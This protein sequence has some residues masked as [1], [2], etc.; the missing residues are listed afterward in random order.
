MRMCYAKPVNFKNIHC[1][2]SSNNSISKPVLR[3]IFTADSRQQIGWNTSLSPWDLS[4][5]NPCTTAYCIITAHRVFARD[6]KSH[7]GQCRHRTGSG[8][9]ENHEKTRARYLL[10]WTNTQ[11][12]QRNNK[13]HVFACEFA[14]CILWSSG[15]PEVPV[16]RHGDQP[17]GRIFIF[18]R[19]TMS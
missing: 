9:T 7:A 16:V 5:Q 3:S 17:A 13:A 12:L 14:V 19:A 4:R 2:R 1:S 18:K 11:I 10:A 6:Q 15:K 8:T